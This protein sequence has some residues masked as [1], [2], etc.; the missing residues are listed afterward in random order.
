[1]LYEILEV[2]E[3]RDGGL[4]FAAY[5]THVFIKNIM[6]KVKPINKKFWD[7]FYG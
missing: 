4:W 1:M 2:G 7:P 6:W 3:A 5:G